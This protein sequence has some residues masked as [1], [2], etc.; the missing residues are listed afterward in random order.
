MAV[1]PLVLEG[2]S[3]WRNSGMVSPTQKAV[4]LLKDVHISSLGSRGT[5]TGWLIIE[6][7]AVGD[8]TQMVAS[9]PR[10]GLQTRKVAIDLSCI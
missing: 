10:Y 6:K 9:P 1:K 4:A 5:H 7:V 2:L 8:E 3:N